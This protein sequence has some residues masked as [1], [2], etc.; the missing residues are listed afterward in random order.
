MVACVSKPARYNNAN[1][2]RCEVGE[3]TVPEAVGAFDENFKVFGINIGLWSVLH[4]TA[5]FKWKG[6]VG[7][8]GGCVFYER[9]GEQITTRLFFLFEWGAYCLD[10]SEYIASGYVEHRSGMPRACPC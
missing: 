3:P 2:L 7:G 6:T 8:H 9:G 4:P 1:T 10:V 5:S